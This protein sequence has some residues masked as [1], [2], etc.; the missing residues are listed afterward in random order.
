MTDGVEQPEGENPS[1]PFDEIVGQ[2]DETKL[3]S[4]WDVV[5]HFWP[6]FHSGVA[7]QGIVLVEYVDAEGDKSVKF[8]PSPN[9]ASWEMLGLLRSATLDAEAFDRACSVKTFFDPDEDDDDSETD[10]FRP[11]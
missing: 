2:F 1:D 6:Q 11:E 10:P 3:S 9:L 4:I 8:I 7:M 5:D